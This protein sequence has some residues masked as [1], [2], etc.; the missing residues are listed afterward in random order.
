MST[1]GHT[2]NFVA[3]EAVY[4]FRCVKVGSLPFKAVQSTGDPE[5]LLGVTDGSVQGF[6][7]TVHAAIGQPISLQNGE[8]VQLTAGGSIATGDTLVASTDGKVVAGVS[9]TE[10]IAQAVEDA[11]DGEVFWAKKIGAWTV[12]GG[13]GGGTMTVN[14]Q[15]FDDPEAEN[16]WTKPAGAMSVYVQMCGAGMDGADFAGI[17][18]SGGRVADKFMIASALPASVNITVGA[19]IPWGTADDVARSSFGTYLYAECGAYPGPGGD[20]IGGYNLTNAAIASLS[21]A[22]PVFGQGADPDSTSADPNG[23][24]GYSFGPGG[25]GG[26]GATY[27]TLYPWLGGQGGA[28]STNAVASYYAGQVQATESGGGGA[29]GSGNGTDPGGNG[30]N[31]SID[32]VTGFGGGGGGGGAGGP[33]ESGGNGGNGIRGGGGGAAGIGN[34]GTLNGLPGAGGDGYVRVTTI[35]FS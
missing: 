27:Y 20:Q 21:G 13:G 6:N 3:E 11:E 31:G 34:G 35:C 2:P 32:P 4:P 26:C 24:Q 16:V 10:Y 33:L 23:R 8:F 12:G 28:P 22:Y 7:S 5:I 1:A 18:G 17:G 9:S 29:G 15:E 25:G 14:V 19:R 30:G